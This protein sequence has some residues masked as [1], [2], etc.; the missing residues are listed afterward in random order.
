MPISPNE[1]QP[2]L[3]DSRFEMIDKMPLVNSKFSKP[4]NHAIGLNSARVSRN[5][6]KDTGRF[7]DTNEKANLIRLDISSPRMNSMLPHDPR[8]YE[9]P[10]SPEATI[11]YKQ[12]IATKT[13]LKPKTLVLNNFSKQDG[14]SANIYINERMKNVVLDNTKDE[15]EKHR[16]EQKELRK[17]FPEILTT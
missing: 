2:S 13:S 8:T 4:V 17:R 7:Y 3:H 14:R 12:A 1:R 15:R 10:C 9:V 16:K 6:F 11:N 5:D